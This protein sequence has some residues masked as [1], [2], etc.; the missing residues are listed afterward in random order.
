M[1]GILTIL[2]LDNVF[3]GANICLTDAEFQGPLNLL[4]VNIVNQCSGRTMGASVEKALDFVLGLG[5]KG[6][7]R[8]LLDG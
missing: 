2:Q 8:G 7:G 4:S 6:R 5:W 3:Q 1:S